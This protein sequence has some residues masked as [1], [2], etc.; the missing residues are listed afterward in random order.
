[1]INAVPRYTKILQAKRGCCGYREVN[2]IAA[3]RS[4]HAD[5]W[6]ASFIAA[7]QGHA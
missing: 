2:E 3:A 4:A 1:M 6:R 7:G 5:V